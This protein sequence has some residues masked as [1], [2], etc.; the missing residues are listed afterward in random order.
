MTAGGHVAR[1]RVPRADRAY[2]QAGP[3]INA[4]I[5][6]NYPKAMDDA[7]ALDA[8]RAA[9]KIRGPLHGI[10]VVVKDNFDL[11]GFP[12]TGGSVALAR[13]MPA[14]DAAVVEQLRRPARSSSARPTCTSSRRGYVR[15][16]RSAARR[17]IPTI[18]RGILA[19]RA[20]APGRRSPQASRR[21]AWAPIPADRFAFQRRTTT[22]SVCGRAR[23]RAARHHPAL[24]HVR[25]SPGQS[26]ARHGSGADA[27]RDGR[28]RSRPIQFSGPAGTIHG[29]AG[30]RQLSGARI[31]VLTPLFGTAPRT[32]RPPPSCAARSIA[33]RAIGASSSEVG[34]RQVGRS[35][36]GHEPHRR[37]VQVRP[38][39]TTWRDSDPPVAIARRDSRARTVSPGA[40][41]RLPPAND[42]RRATADASGARQRESYRGGRRAMDRTPSWRSCTRR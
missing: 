42:V 4:F 41:R 17:A 8:E 21:R 5:A 14:R 20:A 25:T 36:A 28:R 1:S 29:E 23:Q 37:R 3:A 30:G 39:W 24:A 13:L 34:V 6:L 10:P 11:A 19:A 27:R 18:P 9:G 40:R 16:A 33:A 7:A 26:P 32:P 2:D 38:G 22:S 12:T 31:G 35:A 15:S